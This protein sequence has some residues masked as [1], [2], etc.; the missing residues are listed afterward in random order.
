MICRP[1]NLFQNGVRNVKKWKHGHDQQRCKIDKNR[2]FPNLREVGLP[3]RNILHGRGVG[4]K[5]RIRGTGL[6]GRFGALAA[7]WLRLRHR[8]APG[9]RIR[10]YVS[11]FCMFHE[12]VFLCVKTRKAYVTL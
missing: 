8:A 1:A 12:H 2:E 4:F 5:S 6:V 10:L 3:S 11:H 9:M 7:E